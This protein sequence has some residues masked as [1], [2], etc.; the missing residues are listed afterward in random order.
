MPAQVSRKRSQGGF[1][2]PSPLLMENLQPGSAIGSVISV[3]MLNQHLAISTEGME[4]G[5]GSGTDGGPPRR[6]TGDT[7]VTQQCLTVEGG[8][9]MAGNSW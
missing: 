4:L 2:P 7:G 8:S 3:G 5:G 9:P 6:G 1:P